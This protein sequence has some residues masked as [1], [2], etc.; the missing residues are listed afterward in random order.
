[1]DVVVDG[2]AQ[3]LRLFRMARKHNCYVII[4]SW[5]Y[6]QTCAFLATPEL[7]YELRAI[8]P[9]ERFR[10]LARAMGRLIAFLKEHDLP[11]RI[12]YAGLHNEVDGSRLLEVSGTAASMFPEM[13]GD[14][15]DPC[16]VVKPYVEEAIGLLRGQHPDILVS[17]SYCGPTIY[18]LRHLA[19]NLQVAHF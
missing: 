10:A 6:Q 12:A 2:H 11:A 8:P 7:F 3:L 4:S 16:A 14:G 5:E 15:E 18:R 19:G 1:G 9:R 13:A 17:T